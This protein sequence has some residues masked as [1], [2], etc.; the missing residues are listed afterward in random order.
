[1]FIQ[2]NKTNSSANKKIFKKKKCI[3]KLELVKRTKI[4]KETSFSTAKKQ[5][6]QNHIYTLY[7]FPI[8]KIHSK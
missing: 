2:Q 4:S 7:S 6:K 8:V 5:V 1:M 3:I